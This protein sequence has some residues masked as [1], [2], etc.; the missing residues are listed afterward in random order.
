MKTKIIGILLLISHCLFCQFPNGSFEEWEIINGINEPVGWLTTNYE[1]FISVTRDTIAVDGNYSLKIT[2]Q[3]SGGF[4]FCLTGVL[5]KYIKPNENFSPTHLKGKIR[6]NINDPGDYILFNI[7]YWE[8]DGFTRGESLFIRDELI[9]FTNFEIPIELI[10][11]DSLVLRISVGDSPGPSTD[12]CSSDTEA[13]LDDLHFYDSNNNLINDLQDRLCNF[14]VYPNPLDSN[15]EL[16]VRTTS[17][18]KIKY[19]ALYDQIGRLIKKEEVNRI[20]R[21]SIDTSGLSKGLYF[22][23][24]ICDQNMKEIH[25]IIKT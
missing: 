25:K 12:V 4:I 3:L 22:L 11:F 16:V 9:E 10:N 6:V 5:I 24:I 17:D 13:W 23:E 20:R 7:N 19:L 21:Q 8:S 2:S 14:Y 15:N 1:S 18:R